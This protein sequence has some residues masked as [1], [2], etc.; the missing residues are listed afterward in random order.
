MPTNH[1]PQGYVL[2]EGVTFTG[3]AGDP[4][5]TL[6]WTSISTDPGSDTAPN[7]IVDVDEEGDLDAGVDY[8]NTPSTPFSGYTVTVSGVEY[9][10][11][12]SGSIFAIMLDQPGSTQTLIGTSGTSNAYQSSATTYMCFGAGSMI[13]TPAGG[14][15]VEQLA[16]GDLVLTATGKT[17]P[18]KWIGGQTLNKWRHGAHMQPVRICAGALG[19]ALPHSDLTVTADHGM[20]LD[21]LVINASA[22]VNGKTIDFV[23]MAELEDSF[24]V[25][26]IETENHDVIFANGAPAETFVD[27]VTRSHFDN[28][29][30]YLDLYEV[31]RVIP[32]MDRPRISSARLVPDRIRTKLGIGSTFGALGLAKSA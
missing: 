15:K 7:D 3:T 26:H 8:Y 29:Q 20:V 22:L 16:I 4:G 32:E 6:S 11:F 19:N 24:T 21:G 18:V 2:L 31:E 30:E 23:S 25:Y 28:Y 9:P 12:E 10:I 14:Q 5:S 17:V 13:T 1:D 27:A